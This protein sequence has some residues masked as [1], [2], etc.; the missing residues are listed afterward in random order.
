M[1]SPSRGTSPLTPVTVVYEATIKQMLTLEDWGSSVASLTGRAF[2]APLRFAVSLAPPRSYFSGSGAR[3]RI[4]RGLRAREVSGSGGFRFRL[5]E[6]SLGPVESRFTGVRSPKLRGPRPPP[7]GRARRWRR[8][9]RPF[10]PWGDPSLVLALSRLQATTR[11]ALGAEGPKPG[12]GAALFF[13]ARVKVYRMLL[14]LSR[15]PGL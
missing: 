8:E 9:G 15:S 14:G 1:C 12:Q 5:R 7:G 4:E 3:L 2:C 6:D 13:V 10:G 11:A